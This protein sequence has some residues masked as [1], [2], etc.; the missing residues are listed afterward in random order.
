LFT[1]NVVG[2]FFLCM[3]SVE[4]LPGY[5]ATVTL[6]V[7]NSL[8][9]GGFD[10]LIT[11]G[12]GGLY[13]KGAVPVG[14]VADWEYFTYRFSE[15]DN[16]GGGCPTGVIRLVGIVNMPDG[17]TPA[18]DDYHPEGAI[19]ELTFGTPQDL[20]FVNQ[21]FILSWTWFDC[22]DNGI[23]SRTGDTLFVAQEIEDILPEAGC[24]DGWKPGV[25]VE[26]KI[27]FCDGRI[28]LRPP[29][30][31][32]GDINLNG[33]ANE[34]ADAV[35]YSNYFI[36]G[37]L[38]LEPY[39]ETRKLASDI[40]DDGIPLTVADLVYLVRI[41]TGDANPYP[42]SGEKIAPFAS[43]ADLTYTLG[44][45]MVVTAQS[46]V[47][48]GAAAFVFRHT[49]V[50]VGTPVAGEAISDMTLRSADRNGELRVLVFSM[51]HNT[52]DAGVRELFT[53]PLSGG[54]TMELV[55][56]QFSDAQGNM[57]AVN[58]A[59]V[60]PPTAFELMQNYPNPFNAATVIRFA[61]PKA[62]DWSL[63]IYNVAGQLV[64]EFSGRSDAGVVSVNWNRDNASS[65]VYFYKLN[66]GSFADT[67]KMILMK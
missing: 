53:V 42:N 60:A 39:F 30:D 46:A 20:S 45:K 35:L 29:T 19:V 57:M 14:Q 47:D 4:V 66:A 3:D 23:S 25:T 48:L 52:I 9:M 67:K 2:K 54:G 36:Y 58:T 34:I 59:K 43:S 49:G 15:M 56:V 31:D 37:P 22:G 44:D 27:N 61:L 65:G 1:I 10:L 40:N 16:C 62:A 41:I 38:V 24:L 21:C 51:K 63:R 11:Y 17:H 5:E 64:D 18:E 7:Y 32:R 28:C 50:E 12:L 26:P 8:A 33:I 55:E 13:F 6:S